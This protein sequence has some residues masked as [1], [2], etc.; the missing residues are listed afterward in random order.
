MQTTNGNGL[1]NAMAQLDTE[2]LVKAGAP[3]M[4]A[5]DDDDDD[6]DDDYGKSMPSHDDLLKSL[7]ALAATSYAADNGVSLRQ[8]QLAA[9]AAVGD[10]ST[11]ERTE[12]A[13]SLLDDDDY[14]SLYKSHAEEFAADPTVA[15]GLEISDFL[16]AQTDILAKSL[17]AIHGEVQSQ[18]REQQTFNGILAKSVANMG[19]VIVSQQQKIDRLTKSLVDGNAMQP[20]SPKGA[21]RPSRVGQPYGEANL[22]KSQSIAVGQGGV[23]G[24]AKSLNQFTDGQIMDTMEEMISKSENGVIDGVD[25]NAALVKYE[26]TRML[27]GNVLPLVARHKGLV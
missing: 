20:L 7:D 3:N 1:Q 8:T 4:E 27:D 12:L 22:T 25:M 5:D 19:R 2:P 10:L 26:S 23:E 21:T 24:L 15:Q 13:K 17:D 9:K 14:G 16:E 18:G 11:D 6:D